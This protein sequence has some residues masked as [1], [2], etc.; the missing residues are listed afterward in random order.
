VKA[1]LFLLSVFLSAP[2]F[3]AQ[4]PEGIWQGY[5]GEWTSVDR[6]GF[7]V[8]LK[9]QDGTPVLASHSCER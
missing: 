1:F 6:L 4:A 2:A 9:T 7:H 8:R 5:D 3:A